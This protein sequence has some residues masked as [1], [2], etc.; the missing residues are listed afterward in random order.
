MDLEP[1]KCKKI[2]LATTIDLFNNLS[3]A[4]LMEDSIMLRVL[5]FILCSVSLVI[6]IS[7]IWVAF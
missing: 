6:S 5:M 4:I 2:S 7:E 1:Y 3:W